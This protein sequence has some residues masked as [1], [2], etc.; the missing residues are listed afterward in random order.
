MTK[1]H[2]PDISIVVPVFNAQQNLSVLHRRIADTFGNGTQW[3]LILVDDASPDGTRKI[4]EYIAKQDERVSYHRL[5]T[6]HGQQYATIYGLRRSLGARV[7]TMDDDLE[8]APEDIPKLIEALNHGF[9]VVI[10]HFRNKTH[11]R[12]RRAGSWLMGCLWRRL[13]GAEGLSITS[14]KAFER[15]ALEKVLARSNVIVE[16]ISA[17]IL[18]TLPR[19]AL[20]NVTVKHHARLHGKSN[21]TRYKLLVACAKITW[22]ALKRMSPKIQYI[23]R[24]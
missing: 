18:E 19:S 23:S 5:E 21:Y 11:S 15:S 9:L 7:I 6:N 24:R 10:A 20:T 13:Y 16:P 2:L 1:N 22:G 12:I 8:H 14:F 17:H 4:A 3:E